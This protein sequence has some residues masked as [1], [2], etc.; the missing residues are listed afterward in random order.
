ME[1][2]AVRFTELDTPVRA[3]RRRTSL[4]ALL[5]AV[6][7]IGVAYAAIHLLLPTVIASITGG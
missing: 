4:L 6:L 3:A 2:A 7:L 1:N 5:G